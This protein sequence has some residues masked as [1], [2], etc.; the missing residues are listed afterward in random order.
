VEPNSHGVPGSG[1]KVG[2]RRWKRVLLG[3]F[4]VGQSRTGQRINL[5]EDHLAHNGTLMWPSGCRGNTS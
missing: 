5:S 2:G 1:D 4:H 3:F